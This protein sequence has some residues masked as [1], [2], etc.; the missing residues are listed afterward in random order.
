MLRDCDGML[1]L[2]NCTFTGCESVLT[3]CERS[4]RARSLKLMTCG[5]VRRAAGLRLFRFLFLFGFAAVL[6]VFAL[7][8]RLHG[9]DVRQLDVRR[10]IRADAFDPDPHVQTKAGALIS[11]VAQVLLV[12]YALV[13]PIVERLPR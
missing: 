1:R 11:Q 13:L 5:G 4:L 9:A 12:A 3:G 10:L 8:D 2:C 6:L 7:H